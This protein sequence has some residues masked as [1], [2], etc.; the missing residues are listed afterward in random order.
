MVVSCTRLNRLCRGSRSWI[1][2]Y[3]EVDSRKCEIATKSIHRVVAIQARNDDVCERYHG[4][5]FQSH[6][7]FPCRVGGV[8][9]SQCD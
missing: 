6:L 8:C 4:L 2:C 1:R 3:F 9:L 7:G 5:T